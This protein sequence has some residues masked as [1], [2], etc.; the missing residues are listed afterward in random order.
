L[1]CADK[2]EQ[3]DLAKSDHRKKGRKRKGKEM[4]ERSEVWREERE[5]SKNDIAR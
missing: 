1:R 5:E 4:S 3:Q 2:Q